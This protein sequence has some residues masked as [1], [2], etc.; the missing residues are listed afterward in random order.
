METRFCYLTSHYEDVRLFYE[1]ILKCQIYK[2]W[3]RSPSDKGVVYDL[4]TALLEVL[5]SNVENETKFHA[6]GFYLYIEHEG[7]DNLHK[8][9]KDK[10]GKPTEVKYYP[11]GHHSFVVRDPAGLPLKFFNQNTMAAV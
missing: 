2:E 8:D 4:G 3:D 6:D 10:G 1:T 11:W 7:L 9:I 5:S